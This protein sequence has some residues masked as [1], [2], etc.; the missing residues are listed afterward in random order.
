MK[1]KQKIKTRQRIRIGVKKTYF[2]DS[3]PHHSGSDIITLNKH[4]LESLVYDRLGFV[5]IVMDRVACLVHTQYFYVAFSWLLNGLAKGERQDATAVF[6][7]KDLF[8]LGATRRGKRQ[9]TYMFFIWLAIGVYKEHISL[10]PFATPG[11]FPCEQVLTVLNYWRCASIHKNMIWRVWPHWKI[12]F[13]F[14]SLQT[15]LPMYFFWETEKAV[16]SYRTARCFW[17]PIRNTL[18]DRFVMK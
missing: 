18:E 13:A 10:L 15:G 9:Y 2:L 11:R 6:V 17:F 4:P 1:Y 7:L 5:N 14:I 3:N 8:T 16:K 12:D